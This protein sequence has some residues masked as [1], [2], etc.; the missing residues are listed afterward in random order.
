MDEIRIPDASD[1][2]AALASV[3]ALRRLADQLELA[4]VQAAVT[5]GW[6]WQQIADTTL[7]SA[8]ASMSATITGYRAI[9][10]RFQGRCERTGSANDGLR[11]RF[12]SDSGSNYSTQVGALAAS[13]DQGLIASSATNTD[14]ITQTTG[15]LTLGSSTYTIGHSITSHMN[16]TA[17]TVPAASTAS[18]MWN[19]SVSNAPTS[20]SIFTST[21]SNLAAG[22]RL[23]VEGI[24]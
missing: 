1:P 14:R 11:A 12:N 22:S 24:I 3:V 4:A 23:I 6:T 17:T 19:G 16:S 5:Q 9:R 15:E 10:F 2:E 21:G 18:Q 8:A 7:G 13:L 20:F